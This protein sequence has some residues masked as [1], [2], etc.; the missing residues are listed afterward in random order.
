MLTILALA[1][2]TSITTKVNY[3]TTV[4]FYIHVN[5][6]WMCRCKCKS[7]N[8]HTS[9]PVKGKLDDKISELIALKAGSTVVS[10]GSKGGYE[11]S[12][13]QS[14]WEQQ[15]LVNR[16]LSICG[17]AFSASP[18]S[19]YQCNYLISKYAHCKSFHFKKGGYAHEVFFFLS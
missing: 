7:C 9:P 6:A 15:P 3:K 2:Q 1:L 11:V 10:G 18:C 19:L 5:I 8:F 17:S 13:N 4:L 12:G 16:S 14:N